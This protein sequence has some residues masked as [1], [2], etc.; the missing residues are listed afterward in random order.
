VAGTGCAATGWVS[1]TALS[2]KSVSGVGG[3]MRVLLTSGTACGGQVRGVCAR[4]G[5]L[6][7]SLTDAVS[8][9]VPWFS[10][11]MRANT[12]TTGGVALRVLGGG[13]GKADYSV[14]V[15]IS[16]LTFRAQEAC[17]SVGWT[18]ESAIVCR[19]SPGGY[20]SGL[21][22]VLEV[23]NTLATLSEVV[24][25]DAP[26]ISGIEPARVPTSGSSYLWIHGSNFGHLPDV[27]L[28]CRD[29]QE[30]GGNLSRS[31]GGGDQ[32]V[33]AGGGGGAKSHTVCVNM[34][35]R[36]T[37]AARVSV[38]QTACKEV[39]WINA[40]TLRCLGVPAGVGHS[41]VVRAS[42]GLQVGYVTQA[43]SYAAPYIESERGGVSPR[44]LSA[45]LSNS[46]A[47]PTISGSNFGTTDSSPQA[48]VGVSGAEA[49]HYLSDS[50]LVCRHAAGAGM[51]L[52]LAVT[53]GTDC[54]WDTDCGQGVF[55][56]NMCGP[57]HRLCDGPL[58]V[59]RGGHAD[60]HAHAPQVALK[61]DAL[62]FLRLC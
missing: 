8:Y 49:T 9:D 10:V 61:L 20:G 43:L 54:G 33:A 19:R 46:A 32:Y 52:A 4:G 6:Y 51:S 44:V 15:R 38:G 16:T 23:A 17:T 42:V 29:E 57:T 36:E 47:V 11:L 53:V 2:L 5:S 1:E 27:S 48:R 35:H 21:S 24:S 14:S 55:T 59:P 30:G 58:T 12:P 41:L 50:S 37:L 18:S 34:G 13:M 39:M 60:G 3:S 56:A 25:Y 45:R 62:H 7:V 40:E 28:H 26:V 22:A 31:G